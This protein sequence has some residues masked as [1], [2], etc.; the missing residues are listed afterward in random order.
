MTKKYYIE[1][2]SKL[3]GKYYRDEHSSDIPTFKE[4][5]EAYLWAQKDY[6]NYFW[7]NKKAAKYYIISEE[8]SEHYDPVTKEEATLCY[9]GDSGEFYNE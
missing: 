7:K 5:S 1:L 8:N 6:S 2:E 3:S 4:I 9:H